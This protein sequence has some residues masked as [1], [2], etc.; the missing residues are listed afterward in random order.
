MLAIIR[1]TAALIAFS[2]ATPVFADDPILTV[3]GAVATPAAGDTWTFEMADLKALPTETFETTTIWTEGVPNFCGRAAF[4]SA[5]A[6]GR[7]RRYNPRG[8]LE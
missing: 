8:R 3:S 6:C 2:L 5:G 4:C 1:N 7:V